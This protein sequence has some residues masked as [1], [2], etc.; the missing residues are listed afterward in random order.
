MVVGESWA[1]SQTSHEGSNFAPEQSVNRIKEL[2][3]AESRQLF[4]F[5]WLFTILFSIEERKLESLLRNAEKARG[6]TRKERVGKKR[7][8]INPIQTIRK[9][10]MC[11][12]EGN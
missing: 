8:Y 3:G 7:S 9:A 1:T 5:V 6:Q 10:L 4:I 2:E 12:S 11:E